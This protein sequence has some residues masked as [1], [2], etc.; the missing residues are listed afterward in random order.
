M[1]ITVQLF[2]SYAEALGTKLLKIELVE[3]STVEALMAE[4]LRLPGAEKL[5]PMPLVAVNLGYAKPGTKLA[6]G[7]EVAVIPPVAGG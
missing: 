2:A 5:P 7:D 1:T 4:I 6:E 3:D